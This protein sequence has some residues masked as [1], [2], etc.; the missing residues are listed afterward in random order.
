[1][2]FIPVPFD[3][4]L[5]GLTSGKGDLAASG[6]AI[7][8]YRLRKVSFTIPYISNVEKIIVTR[9]KLQGIKSLDNL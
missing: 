6:L 4:L 1:M 9:K 7:T 2:V 5:E 3:Q 8:P